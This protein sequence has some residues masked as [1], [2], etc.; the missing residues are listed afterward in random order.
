MFLL[1]ILFLCV[2]LLLTGTVYGEGVYFARDASHSNRSTY[3]K[4]DASG[5]KRM[6]LTRVLTGE[7]TTSSQGML[8]PPPKNPQVNPNVLFDSTVDNVANPSIFVV[9]NDACNYPAYLITYN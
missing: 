9:Y 3:A 4:P 6:Y 8:I 5:H 1:I 7:Y 2:I